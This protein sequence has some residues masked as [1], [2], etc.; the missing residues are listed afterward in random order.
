MSVPIR[1]AQIIMGLYSKYVFDTFQTN[2]SFIIYGSEFGLMMNIF[3]RNCSRF[4]YNIKFCLDCDSVSFFSFIFIYL[5]HSGDVLS[6]KHNKDS[7]NSVSFVIKCTT[8]PF[9]SDR[10]THGVGTGGERRI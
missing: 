4:T 9:I 1:G 8:L 6:E 2:Y 5:I 10:I 7:K 3:G